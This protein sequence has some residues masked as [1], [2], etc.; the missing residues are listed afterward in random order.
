MK[1]LYP[2]ANIFLNRFKKEELLKL[3][4]EITCDIKTLPERIISMHTK[5][6]NINMF[7][8]I[9]EKLQFTK[10]EIKEIEICTRGQSE[11]SLWMK[12]RKGMITA[13]NFKKIN[14]RRESTEPE[15]LVNYLINGSSFKT[16]PIAIQWG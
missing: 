12:Y 2:E 14:N 5:P 3:K 4:T 13:S 7:A 9:I 6:V 10:A 8:E 11:N 15:K 16:V 1:T